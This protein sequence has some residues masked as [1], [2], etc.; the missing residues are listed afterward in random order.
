MG[1]EEDRRDAL[2]SDTASGRRRPAKRKRVALACET[3]RDRKIR[4]DGGKPVCRQCARRRD[5][6][7]NCTYS[8][9]SSS[10]KQLSEQE[11]I[12][13]LQRQIRHLNQVIRSLGGG[14]GG[15]G[16]GSTHP[17][18]GE[19]S[20]P[21]QSVPPQ[22]SNQPSASTFGHDIQHRP[23]LSGIVSSPTGTRRH[24]GSGGGG[25]GGGGEKADVP[26]SCPL[27]DEGSSLVNAMG[28]SLSLRSPVS[29]TLQ[30]EFYGQSSV[31]SLLQQVPTPAGQRA[32]ANANA[33]ADDN[34]TNNDTNNCNTTTTTMT[35][36][37][38]PGSRQRLPHPSASHRTNNNTNSRASQVELVDSLLQPRYALPPRRLADNLLDLYFDNVYIFYP[39]VHVPTFRSRYDA[40][41]M[42]DG[43][44]EDSPEEATDVG[45]GGHKCPLPVFYCALNAMFALGCE[46]S[47]SPDKQA[48]SVTFYGRLRELLR[49][50]ILDHSSLS[51]VQVL[52]LV[53]HYLLTTRYPNR[54]YNMIGMASRMAVGLGLHLEKAGSV[55]S[56]IATQVR[57]RLWHG[58]FQMEMFVSMTLGRP[59]GI[60]VN[61]HVPLPDAIDDDCLQGSNPGQHSHLVSELLFN[62]ENIKLTKILGIILRRVYHPPPHD[63]QSR[64]DPSSNVSTLF[65]L[66]SLL[67][68]CRNAVP[69][70]LNWDLG[71]ETPLSG[72]SRVLRRQ[73]NVLQ[74]RLLHLRVLLYRPS[75][76]AFCAAARP[77]PSRREADQTYPPV[78]DDPPPAES[79][80]AESF[81][82]QCA[83]ICAKN[84]CELV[85]SVVRA[86]AE[87]ATGAWWFS[88]F[89]LVTSGVIIILAECTQLQKKVFDEEM[90]A[91]AWE[92]C[93]STLRYFSSSHARAR[94]YLQSLQVLRDRAVLTYGNP[95]G[96]L[97]S[98]AAPVQ[99][100][101]EQH[102]GPAEAE[103]QTREAYSA[104][105]EDVQI[106]T[107]AACD[108]GF[109]EHD[110]GVPFLFEDW[111]AEGTGGSFLPPN[112]PRDDGTVDFMARGP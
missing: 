5:V 72:R 67:Q 25:G 19:E 3:C 71:P 60:V 7:V 2:P 75:F 20:P 70:P 48:A 64:P 37:E 52:L 62:V 54:C 92:Q 58:C 102:A 31:H 100:R 57:R 27:P 95:P 94:E 47:Q 45:L 65:H 69:A 53:S 18:D 80:L 22:P 42:L 1:D 96:D 93:N 29:S 55:P 40:L 68:E 106:Y 84:A 88:L 17:C 28:A 91:R 78:L 63:A 50:E 81:R 82:A 97:V 26:S 79:E 30:E 32:T 101:D 41:W 98:G 74:A 66:D 59:P 12:A 105:E 109:F 76:T 36:P 111:V 9:I 33:N 4:C 107:D 23:E 103:A 21:A 15:G 90:L 14:G 99:P 39:W 86:T 89:Y 44:Q 110:W 38:L 73:A 24:G 112:E 77:V 35:G 56:T 108:T 34:N 16:G 46:F 49:D 13:S 11:Y 87:A 8:V 83:A 51:H 85:S 43:Q 104:C 6:P 10:A 61:D